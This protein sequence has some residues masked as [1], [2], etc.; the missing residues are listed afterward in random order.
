MK[1]L[2]I[3]PYFYP[4]KGGSQQYAEELCYHLMQIDKDS[5]VD[6]ITYNTDK[7]TEVEN[8]RGMTVYRVPCIQLLPGQFAL[9]NY[10][11]LWKLLKKL[12]TENNYTLI[13]SH[14][15]F[16]ENSW[17]VPFVAKHFKTKSVLTDHCAHHPTHTSSV[18]NSIAAA[19][20]K[21]IAPIV[22]KQYDMVTVTNKATLAFVQSL[23]MKEPELV[24]GGVDTEYFKRNEK[25]S[26]RTLPKLQKDFSEN[27]IVLTFVGR[28]IPSKGPQIL[29]E[30]IKDIVNKHS[31][32]H[33]IFAGGGEMYDKLSPN[34]T[35]QIHFLGTCEKDEVAHIMKNTDILVHPSTHHE[36][37][38]NVLL[39]AGASGC[40]VIATN[41]GGTRELII[42]EET[43]LLVEP[44]PQ[45]IQKAILDLIENKT[46][47]SQ[48]STNLRSKIEK[49]FDW[50]TIAQEFKQLIQDKLIK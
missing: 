15:R 4:H 35:E 2:L 21:F 25:R 30:A 47:R 45:A 42:N 19:V 13:N 28:M 26:I 33:V 24:Y 20:D 38:P 29:Y 1:I 10:W 6:V 36:G 23:K 43:G 39:E 46:K 48:L 16:F 37:F 34:A 7:S 18:V 17:W 27:D 22:S 8:Y 5:K 14:T 32:L 44:N 41:M 50:R 12:N 49:E 3:T 40:A 31:N 11:A 9:P